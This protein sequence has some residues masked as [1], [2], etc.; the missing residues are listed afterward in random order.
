MIKKTIS[1]GV[2]QKEYLLARKK[3]STLGLTVKPDLSIVVSCPEHATEEKIEAFLRK[4]WRWIN[5]QTVFFKKYQKKVYKKE[6]VS[7][8]SFYYLGRQY[9]LIVKKNK[10]DRV[11]LSQGKLVVYSSLTMENREHTKLLLDMW[12]KE[13]AKVV[14]KDLFQE[15]YKV[16]GYKKSVRVR[17]ATMKRKWG[18]FKG[19]TVTLNPLLI[20]ASKDAINYVITHELCHVRYKNHDKKFWDFM[21]EM[22]PGWEKVKEVL[23]V[24]FG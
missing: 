10:E 20:Q 22:Y 9:Q 2:H 16:F 21:D 24:K 4:K 23:E 12:Y 5:A 3:R 14:F 17:I 11:T 15:L 6:Y 7:G 1:F 18:S 8:E 13:R 19:S